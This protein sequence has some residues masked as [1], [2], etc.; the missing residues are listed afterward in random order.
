M[1]CLS[2]T[3]EFQE[4]IL[5][6]HSGGRVEPGKAE[7]RRGEDERF[8]CLA[9]GEDQGEQAGEVLVLS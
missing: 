4:L 3:V 6:A 8:W 1:V 2:V 7:C 9:L 5:A